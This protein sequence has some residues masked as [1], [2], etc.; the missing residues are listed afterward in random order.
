MLKQSPTVT[1]VLSKSSL[2]QLAPM[3]LMLIWLELL[4]DQLEEREHGSKLRCFVPVEQFST[5][6]LE[7]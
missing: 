7:E 1:P 5:F 6:L 3:R 2:F 4:V